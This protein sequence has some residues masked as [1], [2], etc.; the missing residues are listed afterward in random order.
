MKPTPGISTLSSTWFPID[1]VF[2]GGDTLV[3][4]LIHVVGIQT[5]N[6]IF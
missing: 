4:S 6:L 3:F 2:Q 5:L 1:L